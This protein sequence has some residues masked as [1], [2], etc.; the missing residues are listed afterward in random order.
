MAISSVVKN[1]R[2]GTLA[3]ED[4]TG[5][6]I[7]MTLQYEAGDFS[8]SG[9]TEGQTEIVAYWDRGAL[10]TLRKTQDA[11]ATFSFTAH[12][13][14]LSDSTEKCLLDVVNKTGAWSSG[15]ST[16]GANSD[17]W[18]TKIT[19]TIEGSDHGDGGGDHVIT[20]DDCY[21]SLD[22]SEGDPNSFSISG[23]VYGTQNF[24]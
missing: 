4:G 13:T 23:T 24:T 20:L 19:L 18:T 3:I 5:T 17:V 1:F 15:V 2:D 16:R 8:L 21:M 11:H 14:D 6:P 10:C 22:L 12:M 9:L 7:S